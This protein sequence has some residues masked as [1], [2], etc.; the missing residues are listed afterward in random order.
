MTASTV[1]LVVDPTPPVLCLRWTLDER[2]LC[3]LPRGHRHSCLQLPMRWPTAEIT[4]DNP[5]YKKPPTLW[6]VK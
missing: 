4:R 2:H 1:R 6:T 3:H 5:R